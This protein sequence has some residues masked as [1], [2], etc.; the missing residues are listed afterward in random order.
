[1]PRPPATRTIRYWP[2]AVYYKPRG[3]PL[4][5]LDEV[6]LGLDEFEAL[7]LADR[8]GLDLAEVGRRMDVS[9]ATAGR[10]VAEA[11]RKTAEALT[12]GK[13]L[14]IEGGPVALPPGDPVPHPPP[15]PGPIPFGP[16]GRGQG[17]G[18]RG[19]GRGGRGHGRGYG[20]M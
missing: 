3:V 10:I 6:V 11:R 8:E 2:G 20:C 14:R 9:R 15:P 19:R 1:M 13:A 18:G 4:R 17:R 7:R 12:E 16:G 5:E